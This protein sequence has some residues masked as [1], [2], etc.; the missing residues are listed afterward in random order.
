MLEHGC[1]GGDASFSYAQGFLEEVAS[2]LAQAC[3]PG[4]VSGATLGG[5]RQPEQGS[6]GMCEDKPGQTG[7]MIREGVEMVILA[8]NSYLVF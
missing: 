5:W 8:I 1:L 2:G 6:W 4:L 7:D 3:L